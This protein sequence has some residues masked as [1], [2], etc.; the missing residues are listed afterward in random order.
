MP[1]W[2]ENLAQKP[3]MQIPLGQ[4]L[5]YLGAVITVTYTLYKR[6][7][8]IKAGA[9][10]LYT[11]VTVVPTVRKMSDKVER[12]REQVENSHSTNLRDELD[13]DREEARRRHEE[14]I[15]TLKG[16]KRDIGRLDLKDIERGKDIRALSSKI[17]DHMEW[18][19]EWVHT[20]E[21]R[22]RT[23]ESRLGELEDTL[24]PDKEKK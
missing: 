12:I 4:A 1:D 10:N 21:T 7:P 19:R 16:M 11:F 8:T 24:N 23:H 14:L 22:D 17:D 15:D 6:F 20:A 13:Q 9:I 3:W 5:I 18:S 2:W